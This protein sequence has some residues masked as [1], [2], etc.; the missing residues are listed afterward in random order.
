MSATPMPTLATTAPAQAPA[1]TTFILDGVPAAPPAPPDG[2][3][4]GLTY[5]VIHQG[6]AHHDA[7]EV[8]S[9]AAM[10]THR[11][12]PNTDF[13]FALRVWA[14]HGVET[15]DLFAEAVCPVLSLANPEDS[16]DG[17]EY[18]ASS[19]WNRNAPRQGWT[20]WVRTSDMRTPATTIEEM[21]TAGYMPRASYISI[22]EE[23][24]RR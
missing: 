20:P 8:Y 16:D 4:P 3:L 15:Y 9:W 1:A 17:D 22:Q 18:T 11:P 21:R 7:L 13:A 23:L 24:A 12:N 19:R 5:Q 14:E 6:N 10:R 2:Y